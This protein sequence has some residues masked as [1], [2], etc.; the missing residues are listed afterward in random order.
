MAERAAIHGGGRAPAGAAVAA[1]RVVEVVAGL[2][3]L[4]S[5][6]LKAL[7]FSNFILQIALYRLLPGGGE[8]AAALAILMA[9]WFLGAWLVAG[10]GRPWPHALT[11]ALLAFF[12]AVYAW[13]LRA[14]G[15]EDC[16]C[17][18]TAISLP[19]QVT[20]AKNALLAGLLLAA[21][22]VRWRRPAR[23]NLVWLGLAVVLAVAVLATIAFGWTSHR[24][25]QAA[26]EAVA[27]G[28]L[29]PERPYARFVFD[30]DGRPWDLGRGDYLVVWLSTWCDECLAI[31]QP[32]KD[33]RE[34]IPDLPPV[35]GL[36]LGDEASLAEMRAAT[37]PD[38]PLVRVPARIFIDQ[39]EVEPPRFVLVREGRPLAHWDGDLPN[40]MQLVE[41]MYGI[42]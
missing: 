25:E 40:P 24:R 9:E 26:L 17:F 23:R 37:E 19:P 3:L 11:I 36:C 2:V 42:N 8:P 4:A 18:G 33:L 35:V 16:G 38:F 21:A 15:I 13:G 22:V 12:S 20:F 27:A 29:D 30:V 32:I 14:R 6:V 7:D 10:R 34:L 28:P 41:K 5:A 39:V 31:I 1:G